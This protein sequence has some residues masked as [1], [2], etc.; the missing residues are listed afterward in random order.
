[1]CNVRK[2]GIRY[3]CTSLGDIDLR[4]MPWC[5]YVL[6]GCWF[7]A[8]HDAHASYRELDSMTCVIS[9]S[10][11]PVISPVLPVEA[12]KLYILMPNML[13]SVIKYLHFLLFYIRIKSIKVH[14]E[15]VKM[16]DA[17]RKF[18]YNFVPISM[19]VFYIFAQFSACF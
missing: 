15:N 17:Q 11:T 1:M 8:A 13:M 18:A 7:S 16:L 3:L 14:Q 2:V 9:I 12:E 10:I 5:N 6:L 19:T 4:D